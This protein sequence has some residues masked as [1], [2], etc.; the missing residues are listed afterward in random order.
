MTDLVSRA[1]PSAARGG[2]RLPVWLALCVAALALAGC[3]AEEQGRVLSHEPGVYKGPADEE[4]DEATRKKLSER[5][6]KQAF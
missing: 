5:A 4:I 2:V 1:G 6:R 3:R